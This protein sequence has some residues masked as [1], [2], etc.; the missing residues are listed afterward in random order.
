MAERLGWVSP[1]ILIE[2]TLS[3]GYTALYAILG[4]DA[5]ID[6]YLERAFWNAE[7]QR[8]LAYRRRLRD[9]RKVPI[10]ENYPRAEQ[11]FPCHA[12]VIAHGES[13][14]YLGNLGYEVEFDDGTIGSVATEQW[15]GTIGVLT[16]AENTDELRLYHQLAKLILAGARL[17]LSDTFEHGM[18]MREKD[19]GADNQ[20]PHFV[21]HRVLEITGVYDQFN[22]APPVPVQVDAIATEL[23][24]Q[25][26]PV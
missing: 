16:Y 23:L 14:E 7:P 11:I 5:Q 26:D 1:E 2:D 9:S 21:Y 3:A 8:R 13:H 17:A 4:D 25:E 18:T 19:L 20:R 24:T 15:T 12:I 22:A 6:A 10:L